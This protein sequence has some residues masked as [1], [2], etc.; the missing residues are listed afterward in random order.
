MSTSDKIKQMTKEF[1]KNKSQTNL[2][3]ASLEEI[4]SD[5]VAT[6]EEAKNKGVEPKKPEALNSELLQNKISEYLSNLNYGR[7]SPADFAHITEFCADFEYDLKDSPLKK[8]IETLQET[9][10]TCRLNLPKDVDIKF[11]EQLQSEFSRFPHLGAVNIKGNAEQIKNL[12]DKKNI[13]GKTFSFTDDN[14][15]PLANVEFTPTEGIK[16][17][18][19]DQDGENIQYQLTPDNHYYRINPDNSKTE[20]DTSSPEKMSTQDIRAYN[21]GNASRKIWNKF[22]NKELDKNIKKQ[23]TTIS[24]NNKQKIKKTTVNEAQ[25]GT[26]QTPTTRFDEKPSQQ[27]NEGEFNNDT[28]NKFA[29]N[30]DELYWKEDDIIK[31]MFQDWFLA[32]ANSATNFVIHQI[33]YAA[34]GAW[35]AL[36]TSYTSKQSANNNKKE[37]TKDFTQEFYGKV[38]KASQDNIQ[39]IDN[40]A[41]NEAIISQLQN[42]TPAQE[43][44]LSNSLLNNFAKNSG[45]KVEDILAQG[46]PEKTVPLLTSTAKLFNQ[47]T[48]T[49]ARSAILD[50]KMQDYHKFEGM[51]AE[52]IYAQ[53]V[54]EGSQILNS[55]LYEKIKDNPS[56]GSLNLYIDTLTKASKDMDKAL[57]TGQKDYKKKNYDEH[58]KKP[59]EKKILHSYQEHLQQNEPQNLYDFAKAQEALS[60]TRDFV[61]S[62]LKAQ[63]NELYVAKDVVDSRRKAL[64]KTKQFVLGGLSNEPRDNTSSNQIQIPFRPQ[65]RE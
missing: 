38:E 2:E 18:C 32:A 22:I 20:I 42:N 60:S 25:E 53:K 26:P 10:E 49:Y 30:P 50:D 11:D 31:V 8:Q 9:M 37:E 34:A 7:F 6:K 12:P 52:D 33:E 1:I 19:F 16:I 39:S 27:K 46:N 29:P 44:V 14:D 47:F 23:P 45:F 5:W 35:D 15:K 48:D 58:S 4:A 56:N 3:N 21:F 24:D 40:S 17:S 59:K 43:V 62:G 65:G 36:K 28:D 54:K 61:I 55:I 13:T 63:E 41:G 64:N 51:N 57:K